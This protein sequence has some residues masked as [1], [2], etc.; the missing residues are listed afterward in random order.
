MKGAPKGMPLPGVSRA[1]EPFWQGCAEHKLL[2]QRCSR[3][4]THRHAPAPLCANCQSTGYTWEQSRGEGT[5]YSYMVAAHP[6]HASLKEQV[7]Y[8]VAVVKL[9]DCGGVC[10]TSNLMDTEAAAV[11]I[12]MR[13][14]VAWEDVGQGMTLPR[15]VRV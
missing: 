12:G 9:D 14:K 1:T 3:C 13:V 11:R 10:I 15:F 7:P 4:G 2:V 6:V 8:T 5:V